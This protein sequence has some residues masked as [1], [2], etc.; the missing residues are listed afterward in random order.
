MDSEAKLRLLCPSGRGEVERFNEGGAAVSGEAKTPD[1]G[2]RAFNRD[3]EVGIVRRRA[4]GLEEG[5]EGR[6]GGTL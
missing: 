4:A 5:V 6:V 2:G 1:I 3:D